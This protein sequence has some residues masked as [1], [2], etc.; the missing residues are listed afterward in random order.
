MEY[1]HSILWRNYNQ[2]T[3]DTLTGKSAGQYDIRLGAKGNFAEF[4]EEIPRENPTDLGGYDIN[5]QIEE[6]KDSSSNIICEKKE[7]TVRYMGEKSKRKD[8]YIRSQRPETAYPMWVQSGRFPGKADEKSYIL[9]IRTT[10]GRF[11]GRVLLSDEIDMLPECIKNELESSKDSGVY[12][13][14]SVRSSAEAERIYSRLLTYRNLLLYGPPGTGKTSLMQEV[15]NIFN[16]GGVSKVKFDE[17]KDKAFFEEKELENRSKTLWTTFHQS[18]SYE[19]F[20][21]GLSTGT[22]DKKLLEIEPKQGKMLEAS[23]FARKKGQRS[24]LVIDELNRANVSRV[25]GEFITVIEPDKRLDAEGVATPTTVCVELPYIKSG[26]TLEFEKDG[27]KYT[28]RNPYYMPYYFY[29]IASMNSVDKSIFPLD[30]ALR[31]RFYRYDLYPDLNV[32]SKHLGIDGV[33][34]KDVNSSA[35]AEYDIRQI[36]VIA[37]D[38]LKHINDKISLFLGRDYTL[39]HSYFWNLSQARD[40]EEAKNMFKEAIYEQ[41]LPQ[42]EELFRSREEQMMYVLGIDASSKKLP[43]IYVTA[44]DEETELGATD[45]YV[46]NPDISTTDLLDWAKKVCSLVGADI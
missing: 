35:S 36:C 2:A 27:E 10:S 19:E 44:S 8:W 39:G 15:V 16:H 22:G 29:T 9:L 24:L 20:V 37:R 28:V 3:I 30:S 7:I 26:E 43:Y 31:R 41:V 1:V 34:L 23:E 12:K 5:F 4:F 18:Y 38:L 11:Y 40:G 6:V 17:T 25:F 32:L 14:D 42:L 33:S 13:L 45:T 46:Q 21:V